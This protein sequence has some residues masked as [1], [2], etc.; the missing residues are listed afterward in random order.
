MKQQRLFGAWFTP[1]TAPPWV[2][3][4]GPQIIY[5]LRIN[6]L[7]MKREKSSVRAGV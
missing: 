5:V 3:L 6:D 4:F 1:D 7:G 2:Q